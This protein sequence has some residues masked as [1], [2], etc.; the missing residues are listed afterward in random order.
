[1]GEPG[2]KIIFWRDDFEGQ[3]AKVYPF[4]SD[5]K[6]TIEKVEKLTNEKV[7]NRIINNKKRFR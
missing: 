3:P 5:L 7:Y 6:E 4:R 1:M 2:E